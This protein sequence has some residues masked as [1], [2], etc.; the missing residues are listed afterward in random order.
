VIN[1]SI[2]YLTVVAVFFEGSAGGALLSYGSDVLSD[3]DH[4]SGPLQNRKA[5][6]HIVASLVLLLAGEETKGHSHVIIGA[7]PNVFHAHLDGNVLGLASDLLVL[8]L[9]SLTGPTKVLYIQSS[10][11]DA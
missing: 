3:D 7:V 10:R 9:G 6:M 5:A 4:T 11:T 1:Q 8:L 2:L